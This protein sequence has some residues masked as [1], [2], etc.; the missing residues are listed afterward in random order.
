MEAVKIIVLIIFL[1]LSF[2]PF[3]LMVT[4]STKDTMS[5][6]KSPLLLPHLKLHMIIDNYKRA[7]ATILPFFKNSVII[8]VLAEIG[9]LFTSSMSAYVI[10]RYRFP[11]SRLFFLSIIGI[12]VFPSALT[13]VPAYL[14]TVR[15]GIKESLTAQWLPYIAFCQPLSIFLFKNYFDGIDKDYFD[16]ARVEGAGPFAIY[17]YLI[18]PIGLPM[19]ITVVIIQMVKLWNEFIWPRVIVTENR[20]AWPVPVALTNMA[21]DFWVDYGLMMATYVWSAIPI[22]IAFIFLS[23]YFIKGLMEG[24]IKG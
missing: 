24:G 12:M 22:L 8:V 17:R 1:A 6:M 18:L 11:G 7:L 9:I 20:D 21:H 14:V 2:F 19:V 10:S 23:K 15:L 5:Y 13:L 4:I 16:S 3:Y